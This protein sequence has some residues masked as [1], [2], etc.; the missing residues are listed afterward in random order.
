MSRPTHPAAPQERWIHGV[1][2][3]AR[4]RQSVQHQYA[5]GERDGGDQRGRRRWRERGEVFFKEDLLPASGQKV[6]KEKER[7]RTPEK[8]QRG[9]ETKKKSSP[10]PVT[11]LEA[12]EGSG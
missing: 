12:E 11:V 10:L 8:A 6:T 4:H 5:E 7:E 1:S 2:Q 3:P 9:E